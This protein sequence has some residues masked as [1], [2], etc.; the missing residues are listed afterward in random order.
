MW[1]SKSKLFL[2]LA[3][4]ALASC[5]YEPEVSWQPTLDVEKYTADC[6]LGGGF[7]K[8]IVRCQEDTVMVY[9]NEDWNTS[10]YGGSE[11]C[12]N[13]TCD[14]L[15]EDSSKFNNWICSYIDDYRRIHY[16]VDPEQIVTLEMSDHFIW[17]ETFDVSRLNEGLHTLHA[18]ELKNW[19][20]VL[21][22]TF[23][24]DTL[25]RAFN[26]K[27]IKLTT[28]TDSKTGKKY[29][30]PSF[31]CSRYFSSDAIS[32]IR[33]YYDNTLKDE[34]RVLLTSDKGPI[35]IAFSNK[36]GGSLV[37]VADPLIFSNL[38]LNYK[39]H[40]M[41]Q[42]MLSVLKQTGFN[43]KDQPNLLLPMAVYD[44]TKFM[45]YDYTQENRYQSTFNNTYH[46]GDVIDGEDLVDALS[47]DMADYAKISIF[48]LACIFSV[49]LLRRRQQ[50]IPLFNGYRNRTAEYIRQ[51]GL[52]YF[53]DG[54]LGVVYK[55]KVVVFF[56]EVENRLH[57]QLTDAD[58]LK[59][60]AEFLAS[61]LGCQHLDLLP[62]LEYANHA[63]SGKL[64]VAPIEFNTN[65]EKINV[66]SQILRGAALQGKLVA[67]FSN[68]ND[69]N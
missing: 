57:I 13:P 33:S 11:D 21:G 37:F 32:K 62:F 53:S 3:T 6:P 47:S 31:L 28:I 52:L 5:S 42:L 64:D 60:N 49:Y 43:R 41:V 59:A 4:L 34:G 8:Q 45:D 63:L 54:N 14:S 51:V 39:N 65:C 38:A 36:K 25:V 16:S 10:H 68:I 15:I 22:D 46:G 24:V 9:H 26:T 40:A 12:N 55:H 19:G 7:F 29:E 67:L 27:N 30:L 69:K 58:N 1:F 48:F 44:A 66:M 61:S 17:N 50:V 35:A 2:L 20:C 23:C 56:K 18:S